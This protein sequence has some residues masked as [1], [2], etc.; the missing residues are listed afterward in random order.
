VAVELQ[1]EVEAGEVGFDA[2]RLACPAG[3]SWS[4]AAAGTRPT[5]RAARRAGRCGWHLLTHPHL[6]A[7]VRAAPARL[8]GPWSI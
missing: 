5:S 2:G 4:A 6:P 3:W 7:P 8:P 1:V